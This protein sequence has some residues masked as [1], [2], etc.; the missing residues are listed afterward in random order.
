MCA[1]LLNDKIR[2]GGS[3][4]ADAGSQAQ[5]AEEKKRRIKMFFSDMSH[6]K[7]LTVKNVGKKKTEIKNKMKEVTVIVTGK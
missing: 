5:A 3:L 2:I 6:I 1:C 7:Q 4:I